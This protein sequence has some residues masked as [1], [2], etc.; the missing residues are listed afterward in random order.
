MGDGCESGIQSWEETDGSPDWQCTSG[1]WKDFCPV[2]WCS[3][4]WWVQI[5]AGGFH[6]PRTS[7]QNCGQCTLTWL[8]IPSEPWSPLGNCP[9]VVLEIC[10]LTT[11]CALALVCP[12]GPLWKVG[13]PLPC[14]V[15][16]QLAECQPH[17]GREGHLKRESSVL[18]P[19]FLTWFGFLL[20]SAAVSLFMRDDAKAGGLVTLGQNQV[21]GACRLWV[22][23][24]FARAVLCNTTDWV[25]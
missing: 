7:L 25:A 16:P 8:F 11:F 15:S 20:H 9:Y 1:V 5:R 17:M 13:I 4:Y 21:N 18:G 23:Y 10:R 14:L 24:C 6:V 19:L 2:P 12:L 22:L 3:E